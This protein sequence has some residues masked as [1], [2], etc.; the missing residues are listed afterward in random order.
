[1]AAQRANLSI[2]QPGISSIGVATMPE[3]CEDDFGRQPSGL[4]DFRDDTLDMSYRVHC[5]GRPR[6]VYLALPVWLVVHNQQGPDPRLAIQPWYQLRPKG[7][8]VVIVE[9]HVYSRTVLVMENAH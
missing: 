7:G 6:K 4:S 3:T 5:G 9:G 8:A 2:G 1:M